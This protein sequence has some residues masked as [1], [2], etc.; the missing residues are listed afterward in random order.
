[1]KYFN[2]IR[3][4]LI[5]VIIIFTSKCFSQEENRDSQTISIIYGVYPHTDF[6][7]GMVMKNYN[8][9]P[10][11]DS[12]SQIGC[13]YIVSGTN[14]GNTLGSNGDILFNSSFGWKD[15]KTITYKE[16]KYGMSGGITYNLNKILKS[17]NSGFTLYLGIGYTNYIKQNETLTIRRYNNEFLNTDYNYYYSNDIDKTIINFETLLEY[18][19][20]KKGDYSLNILIGLNTF[21]KH[22]LG[23]SI[24]M[25][26]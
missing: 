25:R 18:D 19:M 12:K 14:T 9:F 7:I 5:L 20:L 24:G 16:I 13:Y 21:N 3:N 2:L 17:E 15:T 4:Y 23:C 11:N 22:F 26:L 10:K 6:N 8:F 1:M